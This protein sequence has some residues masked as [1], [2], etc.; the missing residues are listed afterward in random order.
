M[1][2]SRRPG[3]AFA[4]LLLL[5]GLLVHPCL[6]GPNLT[7]SDVQAPD[8]FEMPTYDTP[9]TISCLLHN[10]GYYAAPIA[11]IGYYISDADTLDASAYLLTIRD[12]GELAARTIVADTTVVDLSQFRGDCFLR[13]AIDHHLLV[14]ADPLAELEETDETDNQASRPI[15][16]MPPP[17]ANLAACTP[18]RVPEFTGLNEMNWFEV[19][20]RNTSDMAAGPFW[21]EAYFSDVPLV[22]KGD[23]G[24]APAGFDSMIYLGRT[25]FDGLAANSI[26]H[27]TVPFYF[28][29]CRSQ[30]HPDVDHRYY[31]YTLADADDEVEESQGNDNLSVGI[32]DYT[33][34]PNTV[35][36][37][38]ADIDRGAVR[39]AWSCPGFA[40]DRL[41][42]DCADAE[43]RT[44]NVPFESEGVE[45]FAAVD[46]PAAPVGATVVYTLSGL[47]GEDWIALASRT[48][49]LTS[50]APRRLALRAAHPNPFNPSTTI[51][52]DVG[53][54]GAVALEIYDCAGRVV[55][56]VENRHREPGAYEVVWDGMDDR[57]NAV[58][59]GVYVVR[60]RGEQEG[61]RVG[62][63][64]LVK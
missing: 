9:L 14:V 54:A 20:I 39:L 59:S 16:V 27:R 56:V 43:G 53:V 10:K 28:D 13:M 30:L 3:I 11:K 22:F 33:V 36:S 25:R 51:P 26:G 18:D 46:H 4:V 58:P 12:V 34:V 55:A 29:A 31:F 42:L 6:A 45:G 2:G 35:P 7:V 24:A 52:Y 19:K 38:L 60:L 44:W 48:V 57:G 21:V 62:K 64:V 63:V 5:G 61:V 1:I 15:T 50:A 8:I 17:L 37:F 40:A 49:E 32:A 23:A 41:R 47:V